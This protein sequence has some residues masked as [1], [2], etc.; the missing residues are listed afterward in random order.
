MNE[1]AA[2]IEELKAEIARLKEIKKIDASII[3]DL[4]VENRKLKERCK[5]CGTERVSH[6]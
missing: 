3:F 6:E 2:T 5:Y 1:Q 4:T